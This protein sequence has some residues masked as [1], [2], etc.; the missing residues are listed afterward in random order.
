MAGVESGLLFGGRPDLGATASALI[1][2]NIFAFN[3]QGVS[4]GDFN[5]T[6]VNEFN[7]VFGNGA[8]FF[9]PGPGTLF[10]DPGFVSPT[11]LRLRSG[12]PASGNRSEQRA[13]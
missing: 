13:P 3:Q 5:A 10:E 1:A 9:V 7:V 6:T 12:S 4:I 2:N 8:N 11:N